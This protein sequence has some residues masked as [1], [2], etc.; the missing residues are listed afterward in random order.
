MKYYR[1]ITLLVSLFCTLA[2]TAV[3]AKRS[4]TQ[5]RQ[6]DGTMITVMMRGDE[7]FH[8]MCTEDGMPIVMNADKA[9]CYAYMADDGVLRASAQ[10]A[11]DAKRRTQA[12]NTFIIGHKKEVERIASFA[13]KRAAMRNE[14]R[15]QRLARR[16]AAMAASGNPLTRMAG[17]TGGEGIGVTGKRKG[18][19]ILVDFQDVKMQ[20]AHD[21]AEWNDFFNKVGYNTLGNTGSVHD[22]FYSQSY[23]Q[24]DLSFDVVGPV[25]VSKNMADYGAND[26]KGNDK[27]PGGMIYEA[28][29]LA[30]DKVNFAD[31]D[32]DGDGE[33]DQVF[34]IYAGHSEATKPELIPNTIWP[35]EWNL[36]AAGYSLTLNGVRINTYG[37][38]AE[39]NDY[40]RTDMAG[41]GT[42][43]HE[44]S[45]CLGLPDIYDTSGGDCF[46][47]D[48]WDVMDMGSYAGDSYRPVGYNTYQRWVSGWMQ[49]EVLSKPAD[50]YDL[51]AL[52]DSPKS[53]VIYNDNTPREY[54]ILENRQKTGFDT[55][56]PSHGL[57]V[58][59]VDYY[60]L[61]WEDN[62]VNTDSSHP[63]FSVVAADNDRSKNTLEGD[64]YPG[65]SGNTSLTD[66]STPAT[67][68]YNTY[69]DK[70]TPLGKPVTNIS[71]SADGLISFLFMGGA[72]S[73]PTEL[74]SVQTSATSFRASWNEVESADSYNLQLEELGRVSPKENLLLAEDF[75]EWGKGNQGDGTKDW[76]YKLDDLM[77][78]KGWKGNKVYKGVGRMKLGTSSGTSCYLVSPLIRNNKS[79]K[80][81][82]SFVSQVYRDDTPKVMLSIID[83]E[84][85]NIDRVD[86]VPNSK[87]Q[88]IV[89]DNPSCQ[90][91]SLMVKPVAR[92]YVCSIG[93]YDGGFT[94]SDFAATRATGDVVSVNGVKD[95]EYEFT[96]LQADVSYQWRVQAVKRGVAQK[97]S[98]W[99]NVKLSS[100]NTGVESVYDEQ[101]VI[102]PSTIV[103]VYSLSGVLLGRM[104]Y[105]SFLR[106]GKFAGVYILKSGAK[107]FKMTK[108]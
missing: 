51:P 99:R 11:H 15:F 24:F 49:P 104:S 78:N 4:K 42:A 20:S 82:V 70:T 73:V 18:L 28:C 67:I 39:L 7:N 66:S 68:L 58:I 8:F 50:V 61:I 59:H 92:C 48:M 30:A 107:T 77:A 90:P 98:G 32:W 35:H 45:H 9:Y 80:V 47:M 65:T 74:S 88:L 96:S 63:R 1:Y 72:P 27:D 54:F 22:Y 2:I 10:M 12:E 106:N 95:T 75:S 52:S 21:N 71:E 25:T 26:E 34:V 87:R 43:C 36:H 37:C 6:P 53:Y 101:N 76:G 40:G 93:I 79:A 41:I 19:V 44:F 3:P 89:F 81:T 100:G 14:A 23:G 91:F 60:S 13:S 85:D 56:L 16:K 102:T 103:S 17:A 94:E 57:L 84:G 83:S 69:S 62:A 105:A 55:E 86:V 5:V 38:T 33:V 97:W 46:G 64:T 29:K 108:G 31:Y